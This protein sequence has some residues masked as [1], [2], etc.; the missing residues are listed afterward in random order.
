MENNFGMLQTHNSLGKGRNIKV[1][2]LEA[3]YKFIL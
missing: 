1:T 2:S 3:G